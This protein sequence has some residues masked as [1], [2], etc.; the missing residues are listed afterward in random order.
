MHAH[1]QSPPPRIGNDLQG[2]YAVSVY[3]SAKVGVPYTVPVRIL[4][5]RFPL[6][7]AF[8]GAEVQTLMLMREL[9]A[10]GHDVEFIG[11]C[12]VLLAEVPKLG[13]KAAK[14]NIGPPPV[15]K[16]GAITFF[17]RRFAM[18]RALVQALD[19]KRFDAACMLSLSEKL[20]LTEWLAGRGSNVLW[21]EHDRVGAWLKLNPWLP[22]LKRAAGRARIVCVSE[23]SKNMYAGIG[24][25]SARI[26]AVPN[27]IDL[28]R[29]K[30][31]PPPSA[32]GEG[33]RVGCVARLSEEKGIDVLVH[34]MR[35]TPQATL[36]IVGTGPQEGYLHKLILE[37]EA[38][39]HQRGRVKIIP[40]ADDLPAFYRSLHAFALPSSDHDPFGLVAGE[41]MAL[42]IPTVVTDK[43]GIAA[44]L[45]PGEA[46][47]VPAGSPGELAKALKSLAD[48]ALRAKLSEAGPKAV[49]ERFSAAAMAGQYETLL[50]DPEIR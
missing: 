45:Q 30:N 20:L 22:E 25:E 48:P 31:A 47:V 46:L 35:E 14:L 29:L 39:E 42:G 23:L 32:P 44:H 37:L 11:S 38:H 43:C 26:A 9:K 13:L 4:F 2:R 28:D 27:G 1:I 18:Q 40:R 5:T 50:R 21:I 3:A 34:A 8:G 36:E 24:F 10:R 16:G 49:H 6:E 12:P 19:G 41:A 33:F 17:W 7:S 15:T